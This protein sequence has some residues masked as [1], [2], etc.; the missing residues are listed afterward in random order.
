[1]SQDL[2]RYV[3][4]QRLLGFKFRIQHILLRGF[5][6]FAEEHGDGQ[7]KNARAL[8]WAAHA[9][10]PEQRRMPRGNLGGSSPPRLSRY[11]LG[12]EA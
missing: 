12:I 5:V 11:T 8:A 9:P 3:A 4:L 6:A 10:S 2:A 1:M 7:V